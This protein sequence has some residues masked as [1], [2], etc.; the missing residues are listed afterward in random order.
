MRAVSQGGP[1][2]SSWQMVYKTKVCQTL[3]EVTLRTMARSDY[4][5]HC[6]AGKSRI[7]GEEATAREA[8]RWQ[9]VS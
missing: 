2:V 9:D 4:G 6:K 5:S 1:E 7:V 3:V 8:V